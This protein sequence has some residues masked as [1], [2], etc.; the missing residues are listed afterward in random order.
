MN[1]FVFTGKKM[2]GIVYKTDNV[3]IQKIQAG[4]SRKRCYIIGNGHSLSVDSNNMISEHD[5]GM[6]EF[7]PKISE[8]N[9]VYAFFFT[10]KCLGLEKSSREIAEFVNNLLEDYEQIFL[11]GHSKCGLCV[12]NA[13][14]Y[15]KKDITLVTIST[16]FKGTIIADKEEVEKVLKIQILKKVYNMIFSDHNVDRDIIPNSEFIR[17]IESAVYRKHI[18]IISSFNNIFCC[19]NIMDLFLF[20]VDKIIKIDG[21]G[22]VPFNSQQVNSTETVNI[23]CSHAS[24][25]KKG[26]KILENL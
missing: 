1:Q 25:L 24:S 7:K 14:Y 16:P 18:N 23:M 15:C 11:T 19:R 21:D 3:I 10:F 6:H 8:E 26:L 13:S 4:K 2:N 22:L 17:N 5:P 12:Y 20:F 9:T